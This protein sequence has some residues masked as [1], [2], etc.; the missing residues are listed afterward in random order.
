MEAEPV[1][2]LLLRAVGRTKGLVSTL[3]GAIEKLL[4]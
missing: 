3:E 4:F 1:S 2:Q